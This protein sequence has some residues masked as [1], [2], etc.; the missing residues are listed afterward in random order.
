MSLQEQDFHFPAASQAQGTLGNVVTMA[1]NIHIDTLIKILETLYCPD[2]CDAPVAPLKLWGICI[3]SDYAQSLHND[4]IVQQ[5]NP[6][7][8]TMLWISQPTFVSCG[9]PLAHGPLPIVEWLVMAGC[10][11]VSVQVGWLHKWNFSG[12]GQGLG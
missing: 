5:P 6:I 11:L 10:R 3:S 1:P 7:R 12:L 4:F 8:V 9:L 2:S